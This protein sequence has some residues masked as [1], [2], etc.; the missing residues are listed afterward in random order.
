MKYTMLGTGIYI[1]PKN[2]SKSSVHMIFCSRT[3]TSLFERGNTKRQEKQE[4]EER[5][6]RNWKGRRVA[7]KINEKFLSLLFG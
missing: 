2:Q 6:E 1:L 7:N 3:L 5:M 4:A